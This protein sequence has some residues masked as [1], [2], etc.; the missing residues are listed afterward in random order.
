MVD[1]EQL[2][3]KA[4]LAEQAERYDDMAAAMKSVSLPVSFLITILMAITVL[5]VSSFLIVTVTQMSVSPRKAVRMS[6]RA[7][8]CY[9]MDREYSCL[10]PV[11]MIWPFKNNR[12]NVGPLH[13][14]FPS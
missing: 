10:D 3:Q 2:V 7:M 5:S 9:R 14:F 12:I 13:G 11:Y 4:R 6:V 8:L 1:R